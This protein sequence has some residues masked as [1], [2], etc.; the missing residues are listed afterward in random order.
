MTMT[1]ARELEAKFWKALKSDRT[2]ML[3]VAGIDEGLG[4]PMTA[5]VEEEGGLHTAWIFTAKDTDFAR[6]L[7]QQGRAIA[8]FASKGHDLFAAIEGELF[9]DMDRAAI[10]RL[11]SPFVAA[12]YEGGKDDPNLLLLRFE[13]ENA[14]VWLNE[15]SLFAGVKMLLGRDP[16]RDYRDKVG[17][18]RLN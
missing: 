16:K 3:G 1:D 6:A 5:L 4:Q 2:I 15:N 10:D 9:V 7:G 17:E 12:W 14:Q 11:W 8:H 13:P 18:V